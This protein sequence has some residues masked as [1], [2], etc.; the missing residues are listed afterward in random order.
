VERVSDEEGLRWL[1]HVMSEIRAIKIG[2]TRRR[3]LE[4]FEPDGGFAPIPNP[5]FVHRRFP[6]KVEVHFSPA[7]KQKKGKLSEI[8]SD[9]DLIVSISRPYFD[10][11]TM[12]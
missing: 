10:V 12:D 4:A 1:S 5:H 7:A 3:L 9:D 11:K 6:I 2:D 8:E